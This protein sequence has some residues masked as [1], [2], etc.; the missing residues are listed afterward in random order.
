MD[1]YTQIREKFEQRKTI[2]GTNMTM[3]SSPSFIEKINEDYLDFVLFDTEHGI[4]SNEGIAPMLQVCRLIGLPSFVRVPYCEYP[5]IARAVDLGADGVMIPRTETLEQVKKA[6]QAMRF[7]PKGIKGHGGYGQMKPGESIEEFQKS[8]FLLLQI[9]S[10]T[11]IEN[12]PQML[13]EYDGEIAAV[14]IGPYDLSSSMGMFKRFERPE[15][16][17]CVQRVFD[18]CNENRKSVGI[19]CDDRAAGEKYRAMG[20]NLFWM[21][22]DDELYREGMNRII[23]PFAGV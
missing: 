16:L 2:L 10:E 13:A 19:F 20:A 15:F 9:E 7:F 4:Y 1:K 6:V 8:R 21:C 3:I 11:G 17:S 22:T 18:I 5:Y 14:V 23:R 12:L